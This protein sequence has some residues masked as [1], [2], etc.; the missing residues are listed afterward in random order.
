MNALVR[1]GK[2][3]RKIYSRKESYALLQTS[4]RSDILAVK[5]EL[6]NLK[7]ELSAIEDYVMA[8]NCSLEVAL[9]LR[10]LN[11]IHNKIFCQK[12][13]KKEELNIKHF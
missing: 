11:P 6:Q 9:A 12:V 10:Q 2:V 8:D 5:E 3:I 4:E 7:A 1:E 13:G